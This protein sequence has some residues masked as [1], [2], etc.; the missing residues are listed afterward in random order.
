MI[1]IVQYKF[2]PDQTIFGRR[3]SNLKM[4]FKVLLS[5][6]VCLKQRGI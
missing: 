2:V 6:M 4:A 5:L 1:A 3:F